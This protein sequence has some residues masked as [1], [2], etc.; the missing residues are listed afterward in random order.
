[1][2]FS[3]FEAIDVVRWVQRKHGRLRRAIKLKSA[4]CAGQRVRDLTLSSTNV[5]AD[6]F[7]KIGA[8]DSF[9]A[10]RFKEAI[11]KRWR[12]GGGH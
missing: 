11:F 9:S 4:P 1:V 12:R 8:L 7:E 3:K 10:E 5:Y 2:R 6:Q